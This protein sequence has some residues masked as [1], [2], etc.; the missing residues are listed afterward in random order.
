[1][2]S[3]KR[4]VSEPERRVI[5]RRVEDAQQKL[6]RGG[7][8]TMFRLLWPGNGTDLLDFHVNTLSADARARHP[9]HY[10]DRIESVYMVLEG[11]AEVI[12]FDGEERTVQI[13]TDEVMLIPPGVPHSPGS[14]GMGPVRLLEIY[15]PPEPDDFHFLP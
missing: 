8:G 6:L 7:R 2:T 5:L 15:V 11:I 4:D 12:L 1:M 3:D 9:L 10:H 14:A 13:R